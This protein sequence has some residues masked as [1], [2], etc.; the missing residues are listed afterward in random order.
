L[1]GREQG[2]APGPAHRAACDALECFTRDADGRVSQSRARGS[3]NGT[4]RVGAQFTGQEAKAKSQNT[5][6]RCGSC[7][8]RTGAGRRRIVAKARI[9]QPCSTARIGCASPKVEAEAKSQD[10]R[11]RRLLRTRRLQD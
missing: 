6:G 8:F 10:T 4:A 5:P 2:R 9:L 7:G 1:Q 3:R 11:V